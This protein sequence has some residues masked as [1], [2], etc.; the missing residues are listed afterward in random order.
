MIASSQQNLAVAPAA[1]LKQHFRDEEHGL[2]PFSNAC[3]PLLHLR[4]SVQPP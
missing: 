2:L 4:I 1:W 3:E